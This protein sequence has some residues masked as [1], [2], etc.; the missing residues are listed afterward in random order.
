M[1]QHGIPVIHPELSC[2]KIEILF[3]LHENTS[4]LVRVDGET[5]GEQSR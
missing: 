5:S 3:S 1:V 2:I 4:F